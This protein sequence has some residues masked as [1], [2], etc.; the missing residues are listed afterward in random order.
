MKH[1]WLYMLAM[2]AVAG[3]STETVQMAAPFHFAG[4]YYMAGDEACSHITQ[5][6]ES[7]VLCKSSGGKPTGY[8]DAMT[9]QQLGMYQHNQLMAQQRQAQAS[10]ERAALIQ[11]MKQVSYSLQQSSPRYTPMPAPQVAPI[12]MPRS[13]SISCISVSGGFYTNCRN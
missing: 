2:I 9:T 12:N 8:R 4:K 1:T 5:I 6:S 10:A 11:Q 7:R 3:C 13:N